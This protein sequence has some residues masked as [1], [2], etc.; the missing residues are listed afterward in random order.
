[1]RP[2]RLSEKNKVIRSNFKVRGAGR[3]T[4]KAVAKVR[5]EPGLEVIDAEPDKISED[6]VLLHMRSASICRSDL[7]FYNFTPAS[8]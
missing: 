3:R 6:E 1:M 8:R 7:G 4:L 2:F 5:R